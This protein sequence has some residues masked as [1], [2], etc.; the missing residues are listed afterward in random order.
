[1]LVLDF[2]GNSTNIEKSV[3]FC[4]SDSCLHLKATN[5]DR[6]VFLIK[7]LQLCSELCTGTDNKCDKDEDESDYV[8]VINMFQVKWC[9]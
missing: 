7:I 8:M 6:N 4:G 2:S 5:N 1:M 3:F 9:A